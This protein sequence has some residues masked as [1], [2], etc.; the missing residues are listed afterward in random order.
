MSDQPAAEIRVIKKKSKGHGGHHGGAW[1]VAYA[2]FVT[3]MMAFFLVMWIISLSNDVKKSIAGYFDDPIGFMKAV[4]AGNAPFS[5]SDLGAKGSPDDKGIG[6][7]TLERKKLGHAKKVIERVILNAPVFKNLKESI[8]IKLTDEG[9]RIDLVESQ[10]SLFF[11]SGSA[12]VTKDSAHLLSVLARELSTLPNKVRFEGHTDNR[13]LARRDGYTNWELS[14]DRANSARRV[15]I[16]GGLRSTQ[17]SEVRG[18]ADTRPRS[19]DPSA[20]SNR[21]VS[22]LVLFTSPPR[23]A[24]AVAQGTTQPMGPFQTDGNPP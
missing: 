4:R 20:A 19:Q 5:V 21:R 6:L 13:P 14:V 22:I 15:M 12:H 18:F 23:N 10:Q 24:P 2:D 7:D 8:K 3:A 1:K 11:D 17:I 9:L 16:A